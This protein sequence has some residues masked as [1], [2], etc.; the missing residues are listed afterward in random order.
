MSETNSMTVELVTTL[1]VHVLVK[2]RDIPLD[3]FQE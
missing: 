1:T 2:V 3:V